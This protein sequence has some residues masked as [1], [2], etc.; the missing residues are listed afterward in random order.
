MTLPLDNLVNMLK[1]YKKHLILWYSVIDDKTMPR[2][3]VASIMKEYNDQ[4]NQLPIV[5]NVV[6]RELEVTK[7]LFNPG[8]NTFA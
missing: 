8:I 4:N 5:L 6:F 2:E 1:R 3:R 7:Q